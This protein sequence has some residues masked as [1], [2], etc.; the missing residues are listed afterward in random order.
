MVE[1]RDHLPTLL[2]VLIWCATDQKMELCVDMWLVIEKGH[3]NWCNQIWRNFASLAIVWGFIM[4]LEKLKIY[5]VK[6]VWY[7]VVVNSHFWKNHLAICSHW[8]QYKVPIWALTFA[9]PTSTLVSFTWVAN[10]Y[11]PMLVG[12]SFLS[13]LF[14]G[15]VVTRDKPSL[16]LRLNVTEVISRRKQCD[17]KRREFFFPFENDLAMELLSRSRFKLSIKS[18]KLGCHS[19]G[20]VFI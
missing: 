17:L 2:W 4:Y 1:N 11:W 13:L 15:K 6:F 7:F 20:K 14:I 12:L 8:H 16:G 10:P 5:F 9:I 18:I 19:S 3:T